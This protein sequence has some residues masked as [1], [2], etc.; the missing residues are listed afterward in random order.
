MPIDTYDLYAA[1]IV[2]YHRL[3]LAPDHSNTT[4]TRRILGYFDSLGRML[5][6]RVHYE[7]K[8]YDLTWWDY[9]KK[10][11]LFFHIEHENNTDK[12]H[13]IDET[14]SKKILSSEADI[15]IA[16]CYP[17]T[18]EESEEIITWIKDRG[19]KLLQAKEAFIILDG[20]CWGEKTVD[21]VSVFIKK[22]KIIVQRD[23][24]ILGKDGYYTIDIED[25]E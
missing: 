10:N 6:Y 8:R 2:N 11:E 13:I 23:K 25:E 1:I 18:K 7:K 4:W 3:E 17:K 22:K 15:V 9:S 20:F 21:F 16:I 14:L 19:N 5:G 12:T 24:R